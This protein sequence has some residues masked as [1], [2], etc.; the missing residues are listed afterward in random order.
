MGSVKRTHE[1]EGESGGGMYGKNRKGN[2]GMHLSFSNT[3]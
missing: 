3:N 2:R 1:I